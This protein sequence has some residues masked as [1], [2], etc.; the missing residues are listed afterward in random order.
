MGMK[1]GFGVDCKLP[2]QL[3]SPIIKYDLLKPDHVKLVQDLIASPQCLYV[4]FAPP[5]G[6]S[7]RARLIQRR[8]RW[9]PPIIRTDKHPD[10]IPELS[11]TLKA[12]VE[13]ANQLYHI[14]CQLITWCIE[15]DTYFSVENPGRSFMWQTAPF[16]ALVQS[17]PNLLEVFFHHC[18]Y[19]SSRRKLT[20]LLHNIPEFATLEAF[21]LNDHEHEPWGPNSEGGWTTAEET[22][23]PWDL[24]R[25][26]ASKLITQL[27]KDGVACTPPVF[28]L[29]EASLQTLRTATDIQ[30]RKNLPPMV[31]EFVQIMPHPANQ[32]I[33]AQAR[34]LSTQF[35]GGRS[36]SATDQTSITIGIHRTPDEFVREAITIGHPTR[37]QSMFPDEIT[38]V[39]HKYINAGPTNMALS[40][41]EE[42]KRW[43]SLSKDLQHAEAE[44]RANMSTRRQKILE[45][46]K[47]ALLR[48]LLLDAG[49]SDLNLVDDL[50]AG[51]NLTGALPESHAFAK[52]VRPAT[53]SCEELRSVADLCKKSML[54][55]T[56]SSGDTEL[57]EQLYEA[58]CKEVSKGFLEGPLDPGTPPCWGHL[59]QEVWSQ[60]EVQNQ[61]N[62]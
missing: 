47:L 41:T 35:L 55:M 10:G 2:S 5:C 45:G 54:E 17:T 36:A 61:T 60:A 25:A 31:S 24:C 53:I 51:F 44:I 23:Y 33:P 4:H 42:I 48:S 59:D 49:H 8:G 28:A 56:Q 14:T 37:L 58:T 15:H 27:S 22:A 26:L 52:R 9:N 39:V 12:R 62:R 30:P 20:K 18:R 43:I 3:R 11:G 38:E 57:D 16:V 6:T 29:Q 13:A 50:I 7:S 32:P 1:N 40:R 21:C 46:K 34:K 19:G